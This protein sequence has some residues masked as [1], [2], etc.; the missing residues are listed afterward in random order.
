MIPPTA[1]TT[2]RLWPLALARA[3]ARR[4]LLRS[5]LAWGGFELCLN[6]WLH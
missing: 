1:A 5:V 6:I 4:W 3:T 2:A